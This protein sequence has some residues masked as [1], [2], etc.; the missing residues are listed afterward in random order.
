[1]GGGG[2]GCHRA[3]AAFRAA[4]REAGEALRGQLAGILA[5]DA[6]EVGRALAGILSEG[7]PVPV[8]DVAPGP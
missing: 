3:E 8:A 2:S 1:M 4:S 7:S 5:R 6:E